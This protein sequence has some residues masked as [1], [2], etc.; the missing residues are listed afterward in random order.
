MRRDRREGF[1][2]SSGEGVDEGQ[3]G[4]RVF[5]GGESGSGD[6]VY[7]DARDAGR[8]CAV[9]VRQEAVRIELIDEESVQGVQAGRTQQPGGPGW[10]HRGPRRVLHCSG[11]ALTFKLFSV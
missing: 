2:V 11:I 9:L 3:V 1:L 6:A 5:R 7:V 8:D 10:V 4:R